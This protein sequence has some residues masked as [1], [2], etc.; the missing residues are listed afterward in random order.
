MR[1]PSEF[2]REGF[3]DTLHQNARCSH[4]FPELQ[5]E[6]ESSRSVAHPPARSRRAMAQSGFFRAPEKISR[7]RD[8]HLD[9]MSANDSAQLHH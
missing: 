1:Q 4:F 5:I 6:R 2:R 9:R 3:A 7:E 8:T